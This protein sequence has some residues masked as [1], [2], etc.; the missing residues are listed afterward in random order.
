[1]KR[2]KNITNLLIIIITISPIVI[3]SCKEEVRQTVY[4]DQ[5]TK[6]YVVFQTGSWWRYKE[7]TTGVIDSISVYNFKN[8]ITRNEEF[9][10]V[11]I[12]SSF[13]NLY[14]NSF[15]VENSAIWAN[16]DF[17]RKQN[18]GIVEEQY[19]WFLFPNIVFIPFDN[20]GDN[21]WIW[22]NDTIQY[23]N[24]YDSLEVN[25][26]QYYDVMELSSSLY[27]DDKKQE[28]IYW[29]KHIGRIKWETFG[30]EVWELTDYNVIQ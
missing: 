17:D 18:I 3:S 26:K 9:A 4:I 8:E 20:V 12:E 5:K 27:V 16:A 1:M 15:K 25:G 10:S 19:P 14:W 2:R 6:D 23:E 29:S 11:D 28:K 30:G 22:Q 24:Y 13:M 21:R 7:N